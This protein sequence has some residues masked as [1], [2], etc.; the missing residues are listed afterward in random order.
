MIVRGK[1]KILTF[2]KR[3]IA[4]K[5]FGNCENNTALVSKSLKFPED[6][7]TGT[8]FIAPLRMHF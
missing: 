1:R 3:A 7:R 8:N 2:V 4:S 5:I 6:E